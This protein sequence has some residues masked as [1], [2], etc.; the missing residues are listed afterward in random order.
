MP[1]TIRAPTVDEPISLCDLCFRSRAVWGHDKEF[2]KASRGELSFTPRDLQLQLPNMT[3]SQSVLRRQKVVDD[4]ADLL[5]L[6]VERG[7]LRGG[8]DTALV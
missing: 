3:L 6:F 2:M 8:V 7:A 4:E 5:K 1:L